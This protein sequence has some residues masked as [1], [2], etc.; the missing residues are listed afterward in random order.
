M[1]QIFFPENIMQHPYDRELAEKNIRET[2]S[3]GVEQFSLDGWKV[4]LAQPVVLFGGGKTS[5]DKMPGGRGSSIQQYFDKRTDILKVATGSAIGLTQPERVTQGTG[6]TNG[7]EIAVFNGVDTDADTL[8]YETSLQTPNVTYMLASY[9][10][11]AAFESVHPESSVIRYNAALPG[12]DGY[13]EDEVVVEPGSTAPSATLALM[14]VAGYKKFEMVGVDGAVFESDFN[15][16]EYCAY[17][18]KEFRKKDEDDQKEEL[19]ISVGQQEM[20][21]RR[22]Q[23]FQLQEI[24]RIVQ[25]SPGISLKVHGNSLSKLVLNDGVNV[26]VVHDAQEKIKPGTMLTGLHAADRNPDHGLNFRR[27]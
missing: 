10:S 4:N 2:G 18:M 23:F 25:Q 20:T 6:L 27:D 19:V 22:G 15:P 8:Y 5:L 14:V 1:A 26:S 7:V 21:I 24:H 17:D 13:G 3:L 12:Y 9:N 16:H 11:K